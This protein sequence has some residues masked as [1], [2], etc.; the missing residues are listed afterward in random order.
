[1]GDDGTQGA[2]AMK[3]RGAMVFA[4]DEASSALF[5]MPRSVLEAGYADAVIGLNQMVDRI[6]SLQ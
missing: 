1:M 4:R 5:G 2:E 6:L 3:K